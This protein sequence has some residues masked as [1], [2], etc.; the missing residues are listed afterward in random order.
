VSFLCYGSLGN[1]HYNCL[2]PKIIVRAVFMKAISFCN[3]N[4]NVMVT[5]INKIMATSYHGLPGY[6]TL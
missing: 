3:D 4:S 6:D 1:E 5:E 2:I